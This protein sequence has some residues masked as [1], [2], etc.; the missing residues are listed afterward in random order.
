[1]MPLTLTDLLTRQLEPQGAATALVYQDACVSYS[2][3]DNESR[4][5]ARGLAQLGIGEGDRVALWLPNV[6]AWLACFFA[7]ARLGAIVVAVNTR[8]RSGE[9]ADIVG[10]SAAKA[11]VFWPD[12]RDIDFAGVLSEVQPDALHALHTLIAYDESPAE[13]ARPAIIGRPVIRYRDL[14]SLPALDNDNAR[15][16][17]GCIIFTTSGTTRAPKFVLHDQASITRHARDMAK[18]FAFDAADAAILL[19]VPLCGVLGFCNATAALAAGR[20]LIMLPTF[21]AHAAVKAIRAHRITHLSAVSDIV[22][23]LLAAA[24]E[25]IPFPSLRMVIGARSGQAA[26]AQARGLMLMGVYG[27]SEVQA[28]ISLHKLTDAPEQ[29]ELGGGKLIA[30]EA[31]VRARNPSTGEILAHGTS[32]ELEFL[33]PSAMAGYFGDAAATDAVLTSDGYLKSG[34]LGYTTADNAFIF[35]SRIGDVLRLAGFLVNPL[36]IEA[37]LDTHPALRA[38]QVVGIDGPHGTRAVAFV[39]AEPDVTFDAAEIAA[40]CA[41]RI[42]KFKVPEH[43]IVI[44]AFPIT[45][46]ANGNKVQKAKLRE[47]AHAML[48]ADGRAATTIVSGAP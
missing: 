24:P 25:A 30:P 20:P 28:M 21:N 14:T 1:M 41:R 23:K 15:A 46:S 38:S 17:A 39:I 48:T 8:F 29:R 12:F 36:E 40:Y 18:A 6:P 33:V 3:L 44:D 35:Q 27:M 34:D 45:P 11:L 32:G 7:C 22:A 26:P 9:I 2:E 16:G 4:R 5:V 13:I 42:A 37:V 47:L 43:V 19:T 10:R 31:R